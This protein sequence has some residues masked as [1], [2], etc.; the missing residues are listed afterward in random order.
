M[1]MVVEAMEIDKITQG[2]YSKM[3]IDTKEK[4]YLRWRGIHKEVLE[5]VGG[6]SGDRD[7]LQEKREESIK[8]FQE[9]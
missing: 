8:K 6:K 5:T 9:R 4:Q 1:W 3:Y 7:V 2:E